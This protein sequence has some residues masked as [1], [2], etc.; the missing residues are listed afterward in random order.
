MVIQRVTP[1]EYFDTGQVYIIQEEVIPNW[2]PILLGL[3][4]IGTFILAFAL[5]RKKE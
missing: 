5:I 2:V 1:S 3:A 4:L